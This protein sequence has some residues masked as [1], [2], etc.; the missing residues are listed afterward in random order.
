[1]VECW[2]VFDLFNRHELASKIMKCRRASFEMSWNVH[3]KGTKK[4][5]P[6]WR[7]TQ[8]PL[9]C[10]SAR[11]GR[12]PAPAFWFSVATPE[13]FFMLPWQMVLNKFFRS[14]SCEE[15]WSE[16][17]AISCQQNKQNKLIRP[18]YVIQECPDLPDTSHL[19]FLTANV[20]AAVA[21]N[22]FSMAVRCP[23]RDGAPCILP[24]KT[25]AWGHTGQPM[26]S[27]S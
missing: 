10:T 18:I 19:I 5:F 21:L 8:E 2:V 24:W 20:S 11:R 3:G 12:C 25:N 9:G 26:L 1:M 16:L 13:L 7:A 4:P 22:D 14:L 27:I 6:I 15:I 17:D 23:W